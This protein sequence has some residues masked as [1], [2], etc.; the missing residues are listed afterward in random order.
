MVGHVLRLR[1]QKRKAAEA[2]QRL[3]FRVIAIGDSFN[4]VSMRKAAERGIFMNSSAREEAANPQFPV[5]RDYKTLR[6]HIVK[7]V[8]DDSSAIIPR[9]VAAPTPLDYEAAYRTM[10]LMVFNVSGTLAP[11]PWP[12]LYA[13]TGIEEL[14]STTANTNLPH[15]KLMRIRAAAMRRHGIKLQKFYDLL[16]KIETLPGAQD[17]LQWLRPIVPRSFMLTDSFEEYARPVFAKLGHPMAL[18]NFLET[19]SEGY[20]TR[21]V[22]RLK[23]QK[24]RAVKELQGL[25]FRVIAVGHSFQDIGMLKEAEESI[26][27]QPTDE[28]SSACPGA[29]CV[30]NYEELKETITKIVSQRVCIDA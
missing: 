22:V 26:L 4:D 13:A 24:R 30:T 12:F 3:N 7:I 29:T 6:E 25:N 11:E 9:Q 5:C 20:M 2:F 21:L 1:D 17:F 16:Q 18:T 28:L 8:M 19:D 10:W 15:S 14:K 23:D 27:F